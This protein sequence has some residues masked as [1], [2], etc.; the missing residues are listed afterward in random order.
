MSRFRGV[1]ACGAVLAALVVLTGCGGSSSSKSTAGG[2]GSTSSSAGGGSSSAPSFELRIA[3][4][5]PFTGDLSTFGPS[6]DAATKVAA[7]YINKTLRADEL[8][9]K[10]SV[11]IVDSEDS[12]SAVQP[13]L[14][15]AQKLVNVDHVDAIIGTMS[16]GSTIAVAQS[17]AIPNHVVEVT[18][19][20]SSTAISK[21]TDDNL[22][23]RPYPS[24]AFQSRELVTAVADQLGRNATINVGARDDDFGAALQAR[25][26]QLWK[27]N[28]G[29]IGQSVKWDP[30]APTFTTEAQELASGHP[31]GWVI[32]DFPPTFAKVGPA[33]VRT[34]SW[35]PAKTFMTAEMDT[36]DV[37]KLVGRPALEGL[38]GVAP[39][40]KTTSLLD[41]F[42]KLFKQQAPG[43]A[44]TGYEGFAFDSVMMTFLAALD[45]RSA[46]PL[47]FKDDIQK[48]TN[49]PG[50]EYTYLQLGQAVK[51]LLS[52]KP[53]HY[54]GVSGPLDLD[55][56]G[57]PTAARFD[58]W[59]IKG[60]GFKALKT[61]ALTGSQAGQ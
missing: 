12:Q 59:Q 53:V 36:P 56:N 57:D 60:S 34:G 46:D 1:L 42:N 10:I 3:N 11:K 6:M 9:N 37:F 40:T 32:I 41:S 54:A 51:A 13:A 58:L 22:V 33:L 2:S 28:G 24:D 35:T 25:F 8:G 38:R 30:N 23:F 18:P 47:K 43:N 16:S 29:K 55:A 52:G 61:F 49:P 48:V 31:T 17:V 14:E 44:I 15:A 21:L 4:I 19:T 27:A 45:A 26:E 50:P 39:S 7:G 5:L 20:A